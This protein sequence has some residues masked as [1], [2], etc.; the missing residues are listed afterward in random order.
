MDIKP[1][2]LITVITDRSKGKKLSAALN[3]R[4]Y[5]LHYGFLGHGTAP[6]DVASYFGLSEPEKAVIALACSSDC[7]ADIFNLLHDGF[8]IGRPGGAGIAFSV[9]INSASNMQAVKFI[10]GLNKGTEN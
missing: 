6:S 7:V 1:M 5:A 3:E 8:A 10:M 2:K 9:N 4:G